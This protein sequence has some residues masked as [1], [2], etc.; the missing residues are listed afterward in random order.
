MPHPQSAPALAERLSSLILW[1]GKAVDGRSLIGLLSPHLV[2]LILNRL[3][4]ITHAF[5]RVASRVGAGRYA[6]R[7][8]TPRKTITRPARAK[9][10]LPQ[11][12]AWL[13][14]LVPESAAS[15]SQLRLLLADPKMAALLA[16]APASLGRPLRSLCH[17][18]GVEIP[19]VLAPAP[20]VRP[21]RPPKPERPPARKRREKPEKVRYVFGLRYPSPFANLNC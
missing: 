1:L 16:A 7:R 20:R 3:R 11:G 14:K 5:A 4:A 12:V 9:N 15:A 8:C 10:P 21:P 18:L 17:M 13:V 19:P 6:P 2:M